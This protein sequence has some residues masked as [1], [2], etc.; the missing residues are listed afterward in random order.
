MS[1][2]VPYWSNMHTLIFASKCSHCDLFHST[3][4]KIKLLMNKEVTEGEGGLPWGKL[5]GLFS[6]NKQL[7]RLSVMRFGMKS[8]S[9]PA[10]CGPRLRRAG[11]PPR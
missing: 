6:S 7:T 8:L 3:S 2:T 5:I 10:A 4:R 1:T 9:G 11:S